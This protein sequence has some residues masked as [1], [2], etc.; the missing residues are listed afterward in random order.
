MI[1]IKTIITENNVVH[2]FESRFYQESIINSH[3]GNYDGIQ[4]TCLLISD[5]T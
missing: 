3:S 4:M 5:V 2:V 1:E